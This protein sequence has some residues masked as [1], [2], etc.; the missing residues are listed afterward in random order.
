MLFVRLTDG[1]AGLDRF[2]GQLRRVLGDRQYDVDPA[3]FSIGGIQDSIDIQAVGILV[4]GAI[5]GLAGLIALGLI[6]S[7]QV[8]LLAAARLRCATS[9]CRGRVARSRSPD[10][11]CSH[12]GREWSSRSSAR[13]S[14][15]R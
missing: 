5:A 9:A 12:S 11:C 10:R 13:G 2:L 1:E 6:I 8:A 7:R 15:H 3:A 4:F 14:P